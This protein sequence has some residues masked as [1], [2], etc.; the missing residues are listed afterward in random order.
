MYSRKSLIRVLGIM[1]AFGTLVVAQQTQTTSSDSGAQLK[2]RSERIAARGERGGRREKMGHRGGAAHLMRELNLTDEQRQ[3]SR[4]IMQRRLA[5]T[6]SQREELFQLREKRI[7]G[8]FSADDEVRAKA[9]RQEM[10]ASM[11]GVRAEMEGILTVEQ[12][13]KLEQLKQERKGKLEKRMKERQEFR[14]KN[15]N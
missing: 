14:N 8:T 10:R 7:A 11:E 5:G 12:K 13:T 15:Q 6:K 2:N 3:Q 9:L 1:L 4:A